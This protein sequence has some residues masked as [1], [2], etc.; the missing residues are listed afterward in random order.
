MT[1][2]T[3]RPR[4]D[5]SALISELCERD[6][7][8]IDLEKLGENN[9]SVFDIYTG[10]KLDDAQVKVGRETQAKRRLEFEVY[11]EVN[12]ELA[13]GNRIWNSGW[14][15]SQ[16]K[17]G[18]VRSRLMVNQVRGAC[19]REDVFAATPTLAAM[20]FIL[21]RAA[22]RGHGDCLGLWDVSVAP[23][24]A[25]IEEDVF[26]RPPKNMWK[27]TT[28]WKLLKAMY[29]TQVASL[30]WKMLVRE[31]LSHGQWEVLTSVWC[32]AHNEKEDTLVLFHGDD[33]LAEGHDSSLDKLDEVL[34]AFETRRLPAQQP[35]VKV[36]FCA[37]GYCGTNLGSRVDQI[38]NTWTRWS[39]LCCWKMRDL[40]QHHSRVTLERDK[41]T[42]CTS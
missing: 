31:A 14:P 20:R 15:D 10:L 21:P 33:F 28:I 41:P 37:R 6:V 16:K 40:L 36:S 13:C 4:L 12:E 32:V 9:S 26:V 1:T 35:V 34:G 30:R 24:H 27:D 17:V 29:G 7:P 38:P 23:P 42:L 3:V 5:M 2:R 18:L 25:T 22:S 8:E 39:R 19:K 11:K